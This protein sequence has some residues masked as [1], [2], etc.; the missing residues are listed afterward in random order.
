MYI[1][2]DLWEVRTLESYLEYLNQL[3]LLISTPFESVFFIGDFNAD[4]Y[5]GRAWNNLSNFIHRNT[6]KCF[7]YDILEP[8][9]F[10]FISFGNTYCKWLDHIVGRETNNI[11]ITAVRVLYEVIGSDH[12]LLVSTIRVIANE[13]E[14]RIH[15]NLHIRENVQ[16]M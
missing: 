11:S 3:D 8:N 4:P 13:P 16:S 9:T 5:T 12:L 15:A 10:T 14:I 2:S 6:L 1:K 7:D